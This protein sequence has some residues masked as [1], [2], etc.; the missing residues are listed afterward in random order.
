MVSLPMLFSSLQNLHNIREI[1]SNRGIAVENYKNGRIR[2]GVYTQRIF[3]AA[4]FVVLFP[5]LQA[6]FAFADDV[7]E[8]NDI[9]ENIVN[10]TGLLPSLLSGF[11]YMLGLILGINGIFKL[12][13]H[14]NN[15][16]QTPLKVALIRFAIGGA[17]FSL[18]LI[19]EAMFTTFSSDGAATT[20]FDNSEIANDIS[21]ALGD[22]SSIIPTENINHM[23]AN[24]KDSIEDVPALLAALAYLLGL[25]SGY[26]GLVKLKDHVENPE[27]NSLKEPVIRLLIGGAL[28]AMPTIYDAMYVS[29]AGDGLGVLGTLSSLWSGLG[30]LY[31]SYAQTACNPITGAIGGFAGTASVGQTMCSIVLH[32]GAFPAF[33]TAIAYLIGL[34]LGLWGVLKI[35]DHVLN[36]SQT[37][38]WEGVSRLLAGGAFFALPA[39]I[40][41]IKDTISPSS[42]MLVGAV[43]VTGYNSGGGFMAGLISSIMGGGGC[44]AGGGPLGLDGM[45]TCLMADTMGPIHVVLNFFAFCAG[46]ILIMIGISR[47]IKSAQDGARGPGG[48]GTIMTFATGGALLSYN[49]IIRLFSTTFIGSPFTK[50]FAQMEYTTGMSDPEI[51]SAHAT[52]TAIIQFVIIV[53]LIS[54]VRGIFIIRGVAEGNSQASIMAGITH[55]LAGALAVNLGPLLNAVQT[56][57]G[58]Q[59]YGISFS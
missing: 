54:F 16:T 34:V 14:V 38:V 6:N 27:Q 4:L 59:G 41:V 46:M 49:E 18:P 3:T 7:G 25:V 45:L 58:I 28:F 26:S 2:M 12:K 50:T 33:L 22:F 32:T 11:A 15:P 21:G 13:D 53:G 31:S 19:Y 57:L 43:P 39:V 47:L 8:V 42:A 5:V 30:F 17:M 29:V 44:D 55:I 48:L 9:A 40:I 51:A 23:L 56:T 1:W 35:R 20:A 24:I 52:I 36:P 10:S 37:H